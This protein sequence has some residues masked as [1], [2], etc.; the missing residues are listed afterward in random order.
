MITIEQAKLALGK[1]GKSMTDDEIKKI[2][3]FLDY[4]SD[5]AIEKFEEKIF[6]CPVT[7]LL[8]KVGK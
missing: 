3:D 5:M 6:G 1:T 2:M 4:V 8:T 7:T